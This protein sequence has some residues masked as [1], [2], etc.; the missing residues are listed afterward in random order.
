[1][2]MKKRVKAVPHV[3]L[4]GLV[5]M[6][7]ALVVAFYATQRPS[8]DGSVEV[9]FTDPSASGLAIVPASCPSGAPAV[10]GDGNG[11]VVPSGT[12]G[13]YIA[14]QGSDFCLTNSGGPTYFIPF[15][16][17]TE[18]VHAYNAITGG[19][20]PNVTVTAPGSYH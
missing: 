3:Q 6:V 17:Q 7:L 15:H 12:N 10:S 14:P 11:Y 9:S 1:M 2:T 16:T 20:V 18:I 19:L 4:I 8:I 5:L 13:A